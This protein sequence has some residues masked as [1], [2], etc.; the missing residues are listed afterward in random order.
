MVYKLVEINGVP[1]IKLS[2][3]FEKTSLPG[4]KTVIRVYVDQSTTPS[5][6]VICMPE[7]NFEGYVSG[8]EALKVWTP[9]SEENFTIKPSSIQILTDLL[10]EDNHEVRD[11]SCLKKRREVCMTEFKEFGGVERLLT[12][13]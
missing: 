3:E 1:K 13:D 8:A 10:Y 7:E 4:R 5:F 6:D 2:D 9:F 11:H 12:I